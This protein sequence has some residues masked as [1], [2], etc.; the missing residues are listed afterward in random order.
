VNKLERIELPFEYARL[1]QYVD[2][3]VD[4]TAEIFF[5]QAEAK[6]YQTVT[7]NSKAHQFIVSETIYGV[8]SNSINQLI[9]SDGSVNQDVLKGLGVPGLKLVLNETTLVTQSVLNVLNTN[10]IPNLAWYCSSNGNSNNLIY[11]N[12]YSLQFMVERISTGAIQP[13]SQ[14]L[15]AGGIN[16]MLALGM[17]QLPVN[18]S[19]YFDQI[20]PNENPIIPS[21]NEPVIVG[22]KVISNNQVEFNGPYGNYYWELFFHTPFLVSSLLNTNQKFSD[23]ETWLQYIFN[24]TEQIE[25]LTEVLFISQGPVDVSHEN[26]YSYYQ[27]LVS[28]GDIDARGN[29]TSKFANTTPESIATLLG[30]SDIQSQ[31]I[32]DLLNRYYLIKPEMRF[33]QYEPFRNYTLKT[34]LDNLNSCSQIAVYNDDPF[35]PQAIARLRIGAFEKTIVMKYIDN[36]LDWGDYEFSQYTWESITAAKMYY[37]YAYDLLGTKPISLGSCQDQTPVTFSDIATKY[38]DGNIPQFLIDMEHKSGGGGYGGGGTQPG[39]AYND[40]DD[41]FCIPENTQFVAYWSR[42]E[43]RLNKIRH[44]LNIEGEAV[45]LPLFQPP[46]NPMDLVRAA[47]QG[48]NILSVASQQQQNIPYYRFAYLIGRAQAVVGLVSEFGN[49]L[50]AALEKSDA[51]SLAQLHLDQSKTILTMTTTVKKKQIEELNKQLMGLQVSLDS[52]QNRQTWYTNLINSGYNASENSGINL[53]QAGITIQEVVAGIQG[54]SIAG[55]LAPC[56]FGFSDGGMKFGDAINMGAQLLQTTSQILGQKGGVAQTVA[57]YQR[58]AQD[59]TLQQKMAQYDVEQINEQIAGMQSNIAASQQELIIQKQNIENNNKE[60]TF[61]KTKFTDQQLYQWMVGRVSSIYFQAYKLALDIALTA[62]TAYQ[63][64]LDRDDSFITFSYWD[65]LHKGLLTA[66]GLK[67]SLAQLENAYTDNNERRLEIEKVISVKE[68]CPEEFF[69]FKTGIGG[70]T[71]GDLSFS[72]TQE[73]FD[74]DFPS[75]YCRKIKSISI[76]IPAVLGPYQTFNATLV[77]NS[78]LVVLK[79][80]SS[81]VNYAIYQTAP[82]K[83]ASSQPTTPSATNLRQNW[84]SNQQIAIS[85]GVNDS[86]LFTLNFEDQRYLPFEDTGAVSTWTLS[87]P[88]ETNHVNFDSISDIIVTIRYTAKGGGVSFGADVTNLYSGT[89]KQYQNLRM[90]SFNLK[91]AFPANWREM[92]SDAPVDKA[93]TLTFPVTDNV[94]L[95]NLSGVKLNGVVVQLEGVDNLSI[96]GTSAF[97]LKIGDKMILTDPIDISNN[98]TVIT[99]DMITNANITTWEDANWEVHLLPGQLKSIS[100]NK[101]LDA[102]KL[103]NINVIISYE[104]NMN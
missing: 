14:A 91:Q 64:E 39:K 59:W 46:I 99:S 66:D 21:L 87:L 32:Y 84:V 45:P 53:I 69:A 68:I 5:P 72:L 89:N 80:D 63:Y 51:E 100:T 93:Q 30:L 11:D 44:C 88:P 10:Y 95:P 52:A 43:D 62:Q 65:S 48:Q 22:P 15:F 92:F 26:L 61:Y 6:V 81:T 19:S 17:Q 102:L 25:Y 49:A 12:A 67:L 97:N 37:S 90:K 2:C 86:G 9:N 18:I 96:Q 40:L 24:P 36:L 23:S 56:I 55:Y 31:E 54:V 20:K 16:N 77:Q 60:I 33:W 85:K 58:R 70:A 50:L 13:L 7:E 98:M 57:Q 83:T 76:T 103:L 73:L 104:S 75:H 101:K 4:T 3:M 42:V 1:I 71:K 78:N 41:Y 79:P 35:D 8:L 28:N 74:R 38:A 82:N 34:L 94:V 27:V 47:A 29:V